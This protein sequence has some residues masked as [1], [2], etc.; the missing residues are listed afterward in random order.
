MCYINY[1]LEFIV[2]SSFS[3]RFTLLRLGIYNILFQAINSIQLYVIWT[4]I[5]IKWYY[6]KFSFWVKTTIYV[7]KYVFVHMSIH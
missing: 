4:C 2:I 6:I 5:M 3:V 7:C 1:G